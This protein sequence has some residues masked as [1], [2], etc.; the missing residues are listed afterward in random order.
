MKHFYFAP[1]VNLKKSMENILSLFKEKNFSREEV[2]SIL[3]NPYGLKETGNNISNDKF[4]LDKNFLNRDTK[5]SERTYYDWKNGEHFPQLD[6]IFLM[7]QILQK[8]VESIFIYDYIFVESL[9]LEKSKDKNE[10]GT[11]VHSVKK[12]IYFEEENLSIEE[13]QSKYPNEFEDLISINSDYFNYDEIGK[14]IYYCANNPK[15]VFVCP[16]TDPEE[17]KESVSQ[18]IEKIKI[19]PK[20]LTTILNEKNVQ[21]VSNWKRKKRK[22]K[23]ET[24]L[25][26]AR[27]LNFDFVQFCRV[28]FCA[29]KKVP[30]DGR[31]F[32]LLYEKIHNKNCF[33][34]EY[35]AYKIEMV[36]QIKKYKNFLEKMYA[37]DRAE[38]D[39][40]SLQELINEDLLQ[41]TNNDYLEFELEPHFLC[42]MKERMEKENFHDDFI[43]NYIKDC[44]EY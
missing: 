17:I 13:L 30:F 39:K 41:I 34:K 11:M 40:K 19:K 20:I 23:T 36:K 12:S 38:W 10:K 32:E 6:I 9:P 37:A 8:P 5:F 16:S 35:E 43:F 7:A 18:I 28:S 1:R 24:L 15:D 44:S 26:F 42:Y 27:F 22:P 29:T 2:E 3:F 14:P 25:N 21:T 31:Q 33:A 4:L